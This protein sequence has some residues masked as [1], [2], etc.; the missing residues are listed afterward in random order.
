VGRTDGVKLGGV[1]IANRDDLKI[2][3]VEKTTTILGHYASPYVE[4]LTLCGRDT[5]SDKWTYKYFENGSRSVHCRRCVHMALKGKLR[6]PRS[7]KK[8]KGKG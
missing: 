4:N 8:D 5:S 1:Q 7:A 3:H 6:S 2:I